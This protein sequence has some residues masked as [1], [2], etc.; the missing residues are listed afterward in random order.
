[1][2]TLNKIAQLSCIDSGL[3]PEARG[4]LVW[5]WYT[6]SPFWLCRWRRFLCLRQLWP[7]AG[8]WTSLLLPESWIPS[9]ALCLQ[10]TESQR[11]NSSVC[12]R[13]FF[14]INQITVL[15]WELS[16]FWP[17]IWK[18]LVESLPGVMQK[19]RKVAVYFSDQTSVKNG[20]LNYKL[21][22]KNCDAPVMCALF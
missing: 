13:L 7:G 3:L 8:L 4:L 9:G 10:S 19:R 12:L 21:L 1:M 18:A 2:Q 16:V 6:V 11:L 20:C 14:P 17:F 5:L 22:K 15:A